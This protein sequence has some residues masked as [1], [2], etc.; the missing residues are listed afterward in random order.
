MAS[1][2]N[3][4]AQIIMPFDDTCGG[5]VS[6]FSDE[7]GSSADQLFFI[8]SYTDFDRLGKWFRERKGCSVSDFEM[9]IAN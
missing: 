6:A 3:S 5:S 7:M 9:L 4:L 2:S 8:S 1:N